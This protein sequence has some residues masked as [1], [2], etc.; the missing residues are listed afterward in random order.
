MPICRPRGG[1][2]EKKCAHV[3]QDPTISHRR[4][5]CVRG[6][7]SLPCTFGTV[8]TPCPASPT[9][10]REQRGSGNR[11]GNAH[12]F[13]TENGAALAAIDVSHG[14]VAC[15]H[16]TVVWL[17]FNNVHPATHSPLALARCHRA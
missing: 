9:G 10:T 5:G 7:T 8:R 3:V 16:L 11:S 1:A 6:C 17:A 2:P 15:S 4:G 13:P 14:V 12:I